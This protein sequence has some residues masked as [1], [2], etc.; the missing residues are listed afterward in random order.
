MKKT[1][2]FFDADCPRNS[3]SDDTTTPAPVEDNTFRSCDCEGDQIALELQYVGDDTVT[4]D[5]TR[6][7]NGKGSSYA[8]FESVANGDSLTVEA[9][10][11]GTF[12]RNAG[13]KVTDSNGDAV[14]TGSVKSCKMSNVGEDAKG[15]EGVIAV[16]SFT[17]GD[18][19]LCDSVA[20]ASTIGGGAAQ[21]DNAL[22]NGE[23]KTMSN[24]FEV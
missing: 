4:V 5:V 13:L 10:D 17:S 12:K 20:V 23:M 21:A 18:G 1:D 11:Y 14:C 16:V 3:T 22:I 8:T 6:L 7:K 9:G 19:A 24:P 2:F 15:C